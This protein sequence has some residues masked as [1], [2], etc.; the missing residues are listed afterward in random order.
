MLKRNLGL[1]PAQRSWI[2]VR[3]GSGLLIRCSPRI[4][5]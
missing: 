3:Q 1:D 4:E 5:R 2:R